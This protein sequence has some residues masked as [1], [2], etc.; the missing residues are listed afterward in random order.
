[1]RRHITF[2]VKQQRYFTSIVFCIL[3]SALSLRA[4]TGSAKKAA[5]ECS[6]AKTNRSCWIVIDRSHLF[7]PPTIQMYP[8]SEL[9]VWL[10]NPRYFERY[11]LDYQSSQ[12]TPS[13]DV[14]SAIVAPLLTPLAKLSLAHASKGA[15]KCAASDIS[16]SQLDSSQ[17]VKDNQGLYIACLVKFANDAKEIY[18]DLEVVASP[19]AY[20][21]KVPTIPVDNS[22]ASTKLKTIKDKIGDRVASELALSG[23]LSLALKNAQTLPPATT[24]TAT[25][26]APATATAGSVTITTPTSVTTT[27][28]TIAGTAGAAGSTSTST[29]SATASYDNESIE[30]LEELNAVLASANAIATDLVG[31]GARIADL[32]DP[33]STIDLFNCSDRKTRYTT[34][35]AGSEEPCVEVAYSSDKP[36]TVKGAQ[37]FSKQMVRQISFSLD[38]LNW[39]ANFRE[40]VPGATVKKALSPITIVFGDS[41]WEASAGA[42]FSALPNRSFAISPV[43]TNGTV[44]DKQVTTNV[45]RPTVVPFAAANYRI[46]HDLVGPRW[47]MAW[48]VTGAVGINP[49]TLSADFAAGPSLSFRSLMFSP[50]WHY[51]HDVRLTQGLYVN[52]SLGASSSGGV[53]TQNYWTSSFAIGISIRTPAL[54]GR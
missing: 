46:S 49:N 10:K 28:T 33:A 16:L 5:P 26:P 24:K 35:G 40:A 43:Y 44:T 15:P 17:H 41:R 38:S 7:A 21:N 48:Y 3:F 45:V 19:D 29:T 36:E 12:V 37:A 9:T 14:T 22:V 47:R 13:P 27:I 32:P 23:S 2:E 52:E 1:M 18:S 34:T 50:L 4:Q 42:L 11:F 53:T 20:W 25:S 30:I 51:G 8:G 54:I 6:L 39:V 31:Y